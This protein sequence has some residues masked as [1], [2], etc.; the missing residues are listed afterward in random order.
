VKKLTI[1]VFFLVILIFVFNKIILSKIIIYSASKRLERDLSIKK[2]DINY[3][4]DVIELNVVKIKNNKN[5]SYENIFEAEKI[6]I[7]YNLNTI[8]KDLV[9]IDYLRIQNTK[10]YL[11]FDEKNKK[12]VNDNIG[13]A[14]KKDVDYKPKIYPK[15]KKDKNILIVKTDITNSQ[16]LIK[17]LKNN[18]EMTVNLS[19]MIFNNISNKKNYLHYKDVFKIIL[20]DLFFK[21]PDQSLKDLIK[22]SY[23]F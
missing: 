13:L 4:S 11:E 12:I 22:N 18:N 19:D 16:V 20:N 6:I 23:K 21:V 5:F 15:K 8:L 10:F 9:E 7:K 2:I 1:T 3:F 14:E 17:M